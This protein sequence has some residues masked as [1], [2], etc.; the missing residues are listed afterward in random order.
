ML[1]LINFL[2]IFFCFLILYQ[3]FLAY[4]NLSIVEGM[5][6]VVPTISPASTTLCGYMQWV[7][8]TLP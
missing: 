2:I 4:F 1:T 3:V 7:N 8:G 5:M 6:D